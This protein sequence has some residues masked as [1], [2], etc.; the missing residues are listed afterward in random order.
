MAWVTT[1]EVKAIVK[2][3]L[4]NSELEQIINLAQEE[5]EARA[6]TSTYH[7]Y[8]RFAVLYLSAA[9]ALRTLKT[10]GELAY[11]NKIGTTHQINQIDGMIEKFD[12]LSE[13]YIRKHTVISLN[14]DPQAGISLIPCNYADT[15]E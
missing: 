12:A 7:V 2:S 5:I 4:S 1:K 6:N 13:S 10:S 8:L 9:S 15:E 14:T 3:S 11:T